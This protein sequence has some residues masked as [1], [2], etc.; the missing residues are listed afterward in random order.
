MTDR[1]STLYRDLLSGSDEC[2]DR[3]FLN[4]YFRM[5]HDPG[6]FRVWW[7]ALT[8]SDETLEDAYLMRMAGRFSRRVRGYAKAHGI[9]VIDC[10]TGQRKHDLAEEY[11]AKTTVTRGLFL[12]L[13][14]RAQPPVWDVNGKHHIE[15]KK[16]LPGLHRARHY[17]NHYSFHFLDPDWSVLQLS[18][19][20]Q[21]QPDVP[22]G[23][24]S[25]PG[26][27]G[28]DRQQPRA[29]G[30][31]DHQDNPGMP[32]SPEISPNQAIGRVGSYR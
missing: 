31:E 22:G 20:I 9:P 18:N 7:R 3:I 10:S 2:V 15:R 26:V 28:L 27:S 1:P 30:P 21:S 12:V 29:I 17:V 32:T 25:R 6:G 24:S 16:D 14:G 5:G 19:R 23:R 4:G 13:V 8:G 11:L